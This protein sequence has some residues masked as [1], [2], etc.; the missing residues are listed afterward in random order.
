MF[1][2]EDLEK[3]EHTKRT[4]YLQNF[5]IDYNMS[6]TSAG[7]TFINSCG[8]DCSEIDYFLYRIVKCKIVQEKNILYLNDSVSDH[9]PIQIKL[10]CV[11]EG[12]IKEK[13]KVKPAVP[14]INLVKLDR[15]DYQ[16]L[17]ESEIS[18]LPS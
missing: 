5:I 7:K 9:Y 18:T 13:K 14:K 6:Y 4:K 1:D 3:S 17:V 2:I 15:N 11:L 16:T 10:S 8:V 12:E